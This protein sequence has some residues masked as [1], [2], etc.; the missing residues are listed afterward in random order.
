[1][2]RIT[3]VMMM[4]DEWTVKKGVINIQAALNLLFA[5]SLAG[6]DVM[7]QAPPVHV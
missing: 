5:F 1:L 3:A 6:S 7:K 4:L 2:E